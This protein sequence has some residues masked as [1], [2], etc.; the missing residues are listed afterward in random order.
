MSWFDDVPDPPPPFAK[1][2]W[3]AYFAYWGDLDQQPPWMGPSEGWVGGAVAW[4]I[5]LTESGDHSVVLSDFVAFPTGVKFTME[6]RFSE[7]TL[8]IR[9]QPNN[10]PRLLVDGDDS[11]SPRLGVGF[12]D[13]RKVLLGPHP[14]SWREG[15]RPVLQASG[16]GSGG[17]DWQK[18]GLWLWPLPPVGPMTFAVSWEVIGVAEKTVT[19]D[20]TEL[21]E[22]SE[23]ARDA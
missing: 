4:R 17:R 19:V 1:E 3:Y 15:V 13:G 7:Q 14:F 18:G 9:V 8:D 11:A 10:P 2:E 16:G 20:A 23:R 6:L 22:A 5:V 21:V 12:S